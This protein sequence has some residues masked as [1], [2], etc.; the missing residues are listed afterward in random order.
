MDNCFDYDVRDYTHEEYVNDLKKD[1]DTLGVNKAVEKRLDE[2]DDYASSL[3]Y[4]SHRSI[5][6]LSCE[7]LDLINEIWRK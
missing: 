6:E 5:Q 4:V 3:G 2:I 1:F 7:I